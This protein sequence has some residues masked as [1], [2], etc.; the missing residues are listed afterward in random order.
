[1]IRSKIREKGRE[2]TEGDSIPPEGPEKIK[3]KQRRKKA[4]PNAN[5]P[6]TKE[7]GGFDK[8]FLVRSGKTKVFV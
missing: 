3:K 8:G 5:L 7:R 1:L 6:L 4:T 2:G